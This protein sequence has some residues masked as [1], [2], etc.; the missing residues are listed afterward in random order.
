MEKL[1]ID[2]NGI[3]VTALWGWLGKDLA[4]ILYGGDT[5]HIGA[6]SCSAAGG[7]Y[8]FVL[9]AHRDDAVTCLMA[10][11][12]RKFVDGTVC[13]MGGVHIDGI[14]RAQI[15]EVV[16]ICGE[17]AEEVGMLLQHVSNI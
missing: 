5:P 4:V 14:T 9:P 13:V 15:G 8:G 10:E 2:R 6:V 1:T 7:E 3:S 11:K 16:A 12:L 17:L